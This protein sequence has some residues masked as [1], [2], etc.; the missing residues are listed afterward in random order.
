[1]SRALAIASGGN[2]LPGL[3]GIGGAGALGSSS[4][5]TN[6]QMLSMIEQDVW[7][8]PQVELVYL[9]LEVWAGRVHLVAA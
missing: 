4:I 7:H 3:G 6:Q 5:M 2:G 8:L 9:G 1:M